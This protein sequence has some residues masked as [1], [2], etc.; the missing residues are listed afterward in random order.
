[1]LTVV[2]ESAASAKQKIAFNQA[3]SNA[4]YCPKLK[5]KNLPQNQKC[6]VI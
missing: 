2:L 5:K 6:K 3:L 4:E 1:M